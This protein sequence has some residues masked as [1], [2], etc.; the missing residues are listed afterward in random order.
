MD[1]RS[2]SRSFK[3]VAGVLLSGICMSQLQAQSFLSDYFETAAAAI[4]N[5]LT[6]S[7]FEEV[8]YNDN[9]HDSATRKVSSF[10]NE[11]GLSLDWYKNYENGKY[12]IIGDISYE[13]YEKSSRDSEFKWNISPFILGGIEL[14]GNDRLMF[15]L[16]SRSV[17]E[18]YDTWDTNRTTHIDNTVGLTY[19][20][21]KFARWGVAFSA[22]YYN[23]YYTDSDYKDKSYQNYKFGAAP[24]YNLTEKIKLGINNSYSERKYRNNKS[25]DD[26]KTYEIMPFVD[27]RQ[28]S[29][30]SIH[31]GVGASRTEYTGLSE[32]TDGDGDWQPVANLTFRYTPVSNFFFSY[33]SS[34]EWEDTGSGRGGSVSYYN[35]LRA[36]WQITYRISFSPGVSVDMKDERNATYDS[37]EY[38]VFANL[39]YKFSEHVSTYLGYEYEKNKYKYLS[40]RDYDVNE[41]WLG[42]KFTY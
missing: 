31:L 27:Y 35:S 33:I 37:T 11:C 17:N 12:G 8:R 9:I 42:V 14:L 21:L 38:S 26:S 34:V 18:K 41:F 5:K 36:T 6:L 23:K 22:Q 40:N 2:I 1:M 19:D 4:P 28:S 10:I 15:T 20:F 29:Q 16:S 25:H 3:V 30:F 32:G 24:Y 7:A 13:Y 39:N